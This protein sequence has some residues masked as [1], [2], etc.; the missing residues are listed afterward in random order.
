MEISVKINFVF[1]S[2]AI[3]LLKLSTTSDMK[4]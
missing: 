1:Y 2:V 3:L 4:F